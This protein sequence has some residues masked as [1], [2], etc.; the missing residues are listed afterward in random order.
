MILLAVSRYVVPVPV[1][2]NTKR[3]MTLPGLLCIAKN[4][5]E[6]VA[7]CLADPK[8]KECLDLLNTY[9]VTDQVRNCGPL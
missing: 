6:Q 5:R 4:C 3:A 2:E 7:A 8:C 1:I 9:P